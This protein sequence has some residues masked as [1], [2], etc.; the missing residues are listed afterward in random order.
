[1]QQK[2]E[3]EKE[4]E[5]EE[6]E[7]QQQ[8]QRQHE[9]LPATHERVDPQ[10]WWQVPHLEVTARLWQASGWTSRAASCS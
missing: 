3:K 9:Q 6:E 1:M 5:V 7:E 2:E 10:Y 8:Q 4:E